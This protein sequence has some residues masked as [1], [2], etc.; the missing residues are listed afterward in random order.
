MQWKGFSVQQIVLRQSC[1]H[2]GE[3]ESQ[4]LPHTTQESIPG[5]LKP[6]R[7]QNQTGEYPYDILEK[8]S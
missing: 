6:L 4:S 8:I 7:L 2:V 5:K 1:I 3:N